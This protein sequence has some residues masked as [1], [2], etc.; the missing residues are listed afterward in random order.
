MKPDIWM[1]LYW[2]DL[3]ADTLHLNTRQFGAYMLLIGAYW[4]KGKPLPDDDAMLCNIIR[5][6]L[7]EDEQNTAS[8]L[9]DKPILARFFQVK[10]GV[11][12]HKRIDIELANA[13]Q[14]KHRQRLRT[15]NARAVRWKK[16]PSVTDSVTD[17]PSPSPSHIGT[18]KQPAANF[19]S[20]AE[21]KAWAATAGVG[22]AEAERF[23][24]HFESSGWIDRN[25]H[26]ILNARS[27][28]ALWIADARAKPLEAAHRAG[29][30]PARPLSIGDLRTIVQT[31]EK[32]L[33]SLREKYYHQG[34]LSNSWSDKKAQ[35]EA[36]K[37]RVEI[38]ELN[39]RIES[40]A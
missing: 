14:N 36:G 35:A 8:W 40:F 12:R 27:K 33:T 17:V 34:N 9:E 23:W 3:L 5:Y 18:N 31:K 20:L 24:N 15:K 32:R 19:P 6:R 28:F 2:G 25:G 26:P 29:G 21:V 22:D 1:P 16:Q 4:R 39:H 10:G 11:W 13:K 30:A 38:R 7:C 37:L